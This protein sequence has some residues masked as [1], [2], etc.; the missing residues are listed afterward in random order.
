MAAFF[1]KKQLTPAKR[2]CL[3]LKE[4]RLKQGVSLTDLAARTKICTKHLTALEECRFNELPHGEIYQKNFIKC[5]L[6]ELGINPEPFLKQFVE[7]EIS[8]TPKTKNR[9][10]KK[11]PNFLYLSNLPGVIR[12]LIIAIII[13]SFISYLGLQIK[14]ILEPPELTIFSPENGQISEQTT[15][16][17]RGQTEKKT[18][19][20]INGQE[21]LINEQ[22]QF[23]QII[24]LKPGLNTIVI[25]AEK[26][27]G[28]KTEITRHVVLRE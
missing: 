14:N 17:V 19:V 27:H 24:D 16:V 18:Q 4:Q 7:E 13:V 23:N 3:C 1:K 10:A 9:H 15:T 11:H 28:K 20:L 26:K 22:G 6:K 12:Y 2:I 25:T 21:I 8:F 5:Y